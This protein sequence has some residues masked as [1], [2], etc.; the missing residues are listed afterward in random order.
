MDFCCFFQGIGKDVPRSQRGPPSWEIT[1]YRPYITW[2]FM[3]YFIP[4]NPKVEHNKYD[5]YTVRGTPKCPLIGEN[6]YLFSWPDV[7]LPNVTL[8]AVELIENMSP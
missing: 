6:Y 2:V 7:G 1:D 4:K 5:G 3:G 8:T